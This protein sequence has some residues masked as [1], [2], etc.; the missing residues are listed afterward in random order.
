MDVR[1]NGKRR[2]VRDGSTIHDLIVALGFA[3]R[4]VVI[5]RNGEPVERSAFA[6][7][8]LHDGDVVEVVRPVPGG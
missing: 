1:V 7:V 3:S 8:F 5:E 6:S 2:P 4:Q